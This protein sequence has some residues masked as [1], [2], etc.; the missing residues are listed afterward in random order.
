MPETLKITITLP[1]PKTKDLVPP[2]LK[3]ECTITMD[4]DKDHER[5]KWEYYKK[6]YEK[7]MTKKLEEQIKHMKVP[8]NSMQKDIDA[9]RADY[10]KA[11]DTQDMFKMIELMKKAKPK[12]DKLKKAMADYNEYLDGMVN[13]IARQQSLVWHSV[14]EAEAQ[15]MA[16]KK[17]KRDLQWKKARQITGC[18]LLGTLALAGAAAAVVA[19]V[20]TLGAAPAALAAIGIAVAGIGAMAT[21]ADVGK[22]IKNAA[23][24]HEASIEKISKDLDEIATHLGKSGDKTKGLAKHLDDASRLHSERRRIVSEAHTQVQTL[25][26]QISAHEDNVRQLKG[27]ADSVKAIKANQKKI[28]ELTKTKNEAVKTIRD[29]MKIDED[30]NKIFQKTR[31]LIGDLKKVDPLG[32]RSLMDSLKRFKD[33]SRI[34]ELGGQLGAIGRGAKAIG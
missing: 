21:V 26:S 14:F 20:A 1:V 15:A 6:N 13:N 30:M 28:K 34:K 32:P 17:I 3:T 25:E 31:D 11:T 29:C 22:K 5:I 16:A 10:N 4:A 23:K 12:L 2:K 33:T 19:S 24:M 18:I 7:L 27:E 8:L 9:L